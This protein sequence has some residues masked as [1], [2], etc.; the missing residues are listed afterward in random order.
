MDRK[1]GATKARKISVG[2]GANSGVG[3]DDVEA[4]KKTKKKKGVLKTI[5]DCCVWAFCCCCRKPKKKVS[6]SVE[7]R[8]NLFTAS[9]LMSDAM[10][11]VEIDKVSNGHQIIHMNPAA[12]MLTGY[13]LHL[14]KGQNPKIL[15]PKE[16]ADV[17]DGYL[18]RWKAKRKDQYVT[19]TSL[20]S[21]HSGSSMEKKVEVE[22]I[23]MTRGQI[24]GVALKTSEGRHIP[25]TIRLNVFS[26]GAGVFGI[27]TFR[28]LTMTSSFEFGDTMFHVTLKDLRDRDEGRSLSSIREERT[29]TPTHSYKD[30]KD[31]EEGTTPTSKG[32]KAP[33]KSVYCTPPK[34]FKDFSDLKKW[35][36]DGDISEDLKKECIKIIYKKIVE[37][38]GEMAGK[39][40]YSVTMVNSSGAS[41]SEAETQKAKL[42]CL[43]RLTDDTKDS[44][45]IEIRCLTV[46][47]RPAET[48]TVLRT[49]VL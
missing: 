5:A 23:D 31:K 15:M 2:S 29:Y 27:A 49:L 43:K 32:E 35:S 25:V 18:A 44:R 41:L 19:E 17:H 36:I 37:Y 39:T 12:Q 4:Q 38:L 42:E 16:I 48:G 26:I 3:A 20:S 9:D 47:A 45:F 28:E 34:D 8:F 10:V 24:R 30:G 46:G 13:N 7:E 33:S 14:V 11:M 22:S 21:S 6:G 40:N 1:D